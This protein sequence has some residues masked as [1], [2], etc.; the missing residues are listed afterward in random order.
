MLVRFAVCDFRWRALPLPAH[1]ARL[2]PDTHS[3]HLFIEVFRS[4]RWQTVDATWDAALSE[5]FTINAWG[6]PMRAA[7]PEVR[8]WTP[9][10]S[11]DYARL[12]ADPLTEVSLDR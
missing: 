8:R 10:A 11:A 6:R 5:V 7:V 12:M 3:T 9:Q 4:G 2:S 1:V